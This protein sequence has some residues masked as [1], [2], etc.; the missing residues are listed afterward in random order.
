MTF[1]VRRAVFNGY[2]TLTRRSHVLRDVDAIDTLFSAP[3]AEIEQRSR[4][5][6]TE[7]LQHAAA[8]VPFYRERLASLPMTADA[9][10]PALATLPIMTKDMIRREGK[11]LHSTQ[12]GTRPRTNTSGGSTGEPILLLQD[13]EMARESR[14]GELLYLRWAGHT[15]GEPHALIWGVPQETFG[16]GPS[17]HER[18]FRFANNE[19]YFN[20]HHID[21]TVLQSWANK[22]S[23]LQPSIIES[24]V[25][26]INELAVF[27]EK[28]N[29]R[30]IRPKSI[31]ASAGVL[32]NEIRSTLQRVFEC[33]VLNRY[34]SREVGNVACSCPSGEELHVNEFWCYVE[35]IDE[36]GLECPPGVEGDILITLFANRT[37]PLI[38]YRIE[39]RGI[40]ADNTPCVCG[41]RTKRLRQIAGRRND[42][43]LARSGSRVHGSA[44]N[45]LF[46]QVRGIR[47]YQFMQQSPDEVRLYVVPAEGVD[48]KTLEA[49]L[50]APLA[51]IA[52]LLDGAPVILALVDRIAPSNSGKHRYIINNCITPART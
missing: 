8:T 2:Y 15:P 23:V 36:N 24:Y 40:W 26:A 37:M 35:L 50:A 22:L 6:L 38:R 30:A 9:I 47:K 25:D 18:V 12:P 14:S 1:G 44:V 51:R 16:K 3:R 45:S 33:S 21:D 43:L 32:T 29:I 46:Y 39:D 7:L 11:R 19:H 48:P 10:L 28:R 34:G 41:R 4:R 17:L 13:R 20:C 27:L 5:R 49:E 52:T 31:I 42:F